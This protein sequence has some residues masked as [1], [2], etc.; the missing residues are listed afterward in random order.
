MLICTAYI[1]K[2]VIEQ[3]PLSLYRSMAL[4]RELD[5]QVQGM[6]TKMAGRREG[7]TAE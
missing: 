2:P 7:K 6:G 5:D 1:R 3:L 4:M